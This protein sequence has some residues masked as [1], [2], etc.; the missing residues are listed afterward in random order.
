MP[1]KPSDIIPESTK[2]NKLAKS[3]ED[4]SVTVKSDL[5]SGLYSPNLREEKLKAKFWQKFKPGPFGS[6]DNITATDIKKVTGSTVVDSSWKKPGF[7]E[8]F[9]NQ[10]EER[11]QIRFLFNK[12]LKVA[13]GMLVDPEVNAN[14]RV[15]IIKMLAEMTGYLTKNKPEEKFSDE[16]INKM[17]Q[18][19]LEEFLRQKNVRVVT[20]KVISPDEDK[21]DEKD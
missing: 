16:S 14:A 19:Q 9:L 10:D 21:V 3:T 20:E 18:D 17:N 7:R 15:N 13:E 5:D 6:V 2:T 4:K 8:W 12:S 11:E 1:K